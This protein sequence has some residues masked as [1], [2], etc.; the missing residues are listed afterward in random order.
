M[1]ARASYPADSGT[2]HK[3]QADRAGTSP[4]KRVWLADIT[5][6]PTDESLL[7]LAAVMDL[8]SRKVVGWAMRD[9]LRTEL[10]ATALMMAV[11][12]QR[13]AAGLIH[14][15]GGVQYA[16]LDYRAA[17]NAAD[18]LAPMSRKADCFDN[19]AMES[20]FTL[21]K[22][23][24]SITHATRHDRRDISAFIEGFYN[25]T[26][27]HSAIGYVSPIEMKQTESHP[28]HYLGR[29]SSRLCCLPDH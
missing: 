27:L 28:V 17:L 10:A 5:Y 9:H 26:G 15:N 16:L 22:L 20:F 18:M 8:F 23:S 25:R 1:A 19:A 29:E 2:R 13:A 7:Y 11:Q 14:F 12:R 24:S 6:I 4:P 21:S 3:P